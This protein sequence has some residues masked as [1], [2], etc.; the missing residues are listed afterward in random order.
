MWEVKHDQASSLLTTV[1]VWPHDPSY[2][3]DQ[4]SKEFGNVGRL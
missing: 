4:R 1:I 3:N 2:R